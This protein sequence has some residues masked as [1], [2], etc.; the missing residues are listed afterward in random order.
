M[1]AIAEL[2]AEDP[3][4]AG[5]WQDWRLEILDHLDQTV[6]VMPLDDLHWRSPSQH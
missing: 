2:R 5:E 6:Q 4:S 3:S 1:K